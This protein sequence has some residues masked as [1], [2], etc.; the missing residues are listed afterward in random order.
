MQSN[1]QRL[2]YSRGTICVIRLLTTRNINIYSRKKAMINN[3][4]KKRYNSPTCTSQIRC[5]ILKTEKEGFAPPPMFI[6]PFHHLFF[7]LHNYIFFFTSA[8]YHLAFH[9]RP[10]CLSMSHVLCAWTVQKTQLSLL[11][12]IPTPV[13][14]VYVALPPLR[15]PSVAPL[16]LTSPC[17]PLTFNYQ[18]P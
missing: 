9:F 2:H 4:I 3:T 6:Q 18:S 17:I 12:I 16:L 7:L 11:V 14:L 1:S 10:E 13:W 5:A 8:P 15:V